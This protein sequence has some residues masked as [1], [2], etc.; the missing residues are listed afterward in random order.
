MVSQSATLSFARRVLVSILHLR[1]QLGSKLSQLWSNSQLLSTEYHALR[2]T[3]GDHCRECCCYN[4]ATQGPLGQ[5]ILLPHKASTCHRP[6]MPQHSP[7]QLCPLLLLH[8]STQLR[9]SCLPF[10]FPKGNPLWPPT[11]TPRPLRLSAHIFQTM[12]P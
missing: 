12:S 5:P 8:P 3:S 9:L 2:T 4:L 10:L 7:L 11:S 1:T 6:L